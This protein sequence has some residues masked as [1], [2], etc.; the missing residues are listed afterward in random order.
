MSVSANVVDGKIVI[1]DSLSSTG[2]TNASGGST[3]DK[4]AFLRLLV[5]QMKYQDP[6]EP[7]SNTEYIAQFAQFSSLEQMQ[8]MSAT[9]ELSRASSYVGQTVTIRSKTSTGEI[10]EIEG[11]VDFVVFENGKAFLS[12]NGSL[13]N[14]ADVYAAV[15]PEYKAAYDLA[16]A[17]A[18]ALDSLPDPD[19]ITLAEAELIDNLKDGYNAM[20][21]YQQGFIANALTELLGKYVARVAELRA[22]AENKNTPPPDDTGGDGDAPPAD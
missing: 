5:A 22:A 3:L 17:F 1:P 20:S 7:A 18:K 19:N 14:V 6:L 10:R 15:D 8:N 16:I 13:Y 4:D 12:I 11:K 21:G 2:G 9:L